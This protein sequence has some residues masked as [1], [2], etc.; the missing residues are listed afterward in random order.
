MGRSHHPRRVAVGCSVGGDHS[1]SLAGETRPAVDYLV[2]Q[3]AMSAGEGI[4][5][6]LTTLPSMTSPGVLMIP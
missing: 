6:A 2:S 4:R 1:V 5:P 3:A